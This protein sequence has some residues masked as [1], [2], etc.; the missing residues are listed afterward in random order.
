ML[1]DSWV[2]AVVLGAIALGLK[3]ACDGFKSLTE[4]LYCLEKVRALRLSLAK[5][6]ETTVARAAALNHQAAMLRSGG[7][8]ARGSLEGR[9][10]R[11]VWTLADTHE[12]R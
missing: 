10:R 1:L 4:A 5:A 2:F 8:A 11:R 3:H 6:Q 12:C 9:R 7:A